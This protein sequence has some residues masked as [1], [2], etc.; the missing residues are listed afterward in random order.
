MNRQHAAALPLLV[1]YLLL[2]PLVQKDSEGRDST[3]PLSK[4]AVGASYD[5]AVACEQAKTR[6]LAS[7]THLHIDGFSEVV[8][9]AGD[10]PRLGK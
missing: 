8:C 9:I 4:W 2:P 10:D 1:V 7:Y 5:T 6:M 3:A